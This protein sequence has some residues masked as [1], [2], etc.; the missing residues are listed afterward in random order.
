MT[1]QGKIII[2][3]GLPKT[4]TTT[5]QTDVFPKLNTKQIRYLGVF[6]PR[7]AATRHSLFEQFYDAV[8]TG[9]SISELRE[10][11]GIQTGR[12]VSLLISEEL[13]TSSSAGITWRKKLSNLR[14][15]VQ[16]LNYELILTVREPASALFSY[17]CEMYPNIDSDRGSF[18]WSALHCEAL[19]IFHYGK[20]LDELFVNY[21]KKR[22]HAYRFEDIVNND[23]GD[24]IAVLDPKQGVQTTFALGH[25]NE[26]SK[27]SRFQVTPHWLTLGTVIRRI[28]DLLFGKK[29]R[30]RRS[31]EYRLG[32][33]LM[34]FDRLK[35][36]R[37]RIK[38]PTEQELSVIRGALRPETMRLKRNSG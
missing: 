31:A 32:K 29:S 34:Q 19:E 16:G 15:I 22:I 14:Q 28:L 20:L 5:L 6:H 24:L 2:H 21:E 27:S 35:I 30:F 25:R 3:I 36:C 9:E 23:L 4:A 10:T 37:I 38:R 26:R 1:E 7:S 8:M 11:M 33:L 13:I 12:G 17:Y 18:I